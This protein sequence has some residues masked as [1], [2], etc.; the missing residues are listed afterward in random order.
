MNC[1][2]RVLNPD[3]FSGVLR[4]QRLV[5]HL[6]Y[7]LGTL[8][9]YYQLNVEPL[10]R[11]MAGLVRRYHSPFQFLEKPVSPPSFVPIGTRPLRDFLLYGLWQE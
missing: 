1:K 3:D 11:S 10:N 5:C 9:S 8:S 2:F 6:L 7:I 4:H